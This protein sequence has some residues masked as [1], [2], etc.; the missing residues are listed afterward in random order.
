MPLL[1]PR[2]WRTRPITTSFTRCIMRTPASEVTVLSTFDPARLTASDFV[3]LS[4][5]VR[6]RIGR[7][8]RGR[9]E[10]NSAYTKYYKRKGVTT[11]FP[12]RT[13]GFFYY[14]QGSPFTASA[15]RFR[16]TTANASSKNFSKGTDLLRPDGEIWELALIT[17]SKTRPSVQR[18]LLRDGLVTQSEL[19]HCAALFPAKRSRSPRTVLHQFGQP[20]STSFYGNHWI[21]AVCGGEKHRCHLR[22]FRDHRKRIGRLPAYPYDGIAIVRFEVSKLPEHAGR[23]FAVLRIVK[24]IE[25]PT[26][27]IPDYDGFLPAP[28]EGGLVY[29]HPIGRSKEV[30]EPWSLNLD[31]PLAKALRLLFDAEE[32]DKA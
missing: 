25:P 24:M 22:I 31:K 14:H 16:V 23:R 18:Q 21:Q 28:V 3:D 5:R 13:A 32:L 15:I 8:A 12:P 7:A 30:L 29:R 20:F 27:R 10:P 11:P 6:F 1:F 26:L 19:K 4:S 9:G 2:C 17:I